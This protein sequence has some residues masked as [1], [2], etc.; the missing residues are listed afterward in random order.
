MFI[1]QIAVFLKNESGTLGELIGFLSEKGINIVSINIA[2]TADFG[3]VRLIL[4]ESERAAAVLKDGG[5]TFKTTDVLGVKMDD[6]PGGLFAV[7]KALSGI[8]IEYL[9]SYRTIAVIKVSDNEKAVKA[10]Q[11][12]GFLLASENLL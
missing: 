5:F 2:E 6:K 4:S 1:K 10:L 3:I 11:S 9:Y 8:N 7:L 12:G